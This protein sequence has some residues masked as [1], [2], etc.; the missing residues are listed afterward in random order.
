M[1]LARRRAAPVAASAASVLLALA[2]FGCQ[3]ANNKSVPPAGTGA[4]AAS[5]AGTWSG[6]CQPD[7]LTGCGASPAVATFMQ[8]GATVTGEITTSGCGVS[9]YFQGTISGNLLTGSVKMT[10]CVGGAVTATL[11][12]SQLSL[13][14]GDLTKPLITGEAP[15]MYG[16]AVSLHR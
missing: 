16:G 11:N 10:G 12:G 15:V 2:S 3:G 8:S 9:G 1:R 7:D 4:N 13:A 5:V 14:V 6:S